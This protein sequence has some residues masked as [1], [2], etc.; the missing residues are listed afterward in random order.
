MESK[1]KSM[2]KA[3]KQPIGNCACE[4]FCDLGIV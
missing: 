2:S 3:E 4:V 1:I